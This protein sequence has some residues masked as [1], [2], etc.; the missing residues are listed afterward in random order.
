[1]SEETHKKPHEEKPLEKM[2]VKELREVA[3]EF[4]H[5]RAIHDMKK[6]ELVA[7]IKEAKGIKDEGPVK[8]KKHTVRIKMSKPELKAKIREVKVLRWQAIED[9]DAK[10]AVALRHQLSTLKKISRR[11][12]LA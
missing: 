3:A 11:L 7:F 2:T 9:R 5:E 8:K 12:P 10:K 4:P 6:D 1:M